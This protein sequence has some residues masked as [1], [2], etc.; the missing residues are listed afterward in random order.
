MGAT[1]YDDDAGSGVTFRAWAPF[2]SSVHVAG[3]FNSWSETQDP[4]YHE[5]NG[6]WSADIPAAKVGDEYKF[7]MNSGQ[8]KATWRVDTY[9]REVKNSNG[10]GVIAPSTPFQEPAGYSMQPWNELVIYELHVG[11]FTEDPI[12]GP[13]QNE[14]HRG[15]FRSIIPKL[16]YL[17]DLGINAI[18]LLPANEFAT[19]ISWGYNPAHLFAIETSY[20]G[21][22]GLRD[23]V[24][25]AHQN[26]IAVIFD[27][28]F[29][30][31][32][33]PDIDN[34]VWRF[35]GWYEDIYGGI[36]FYN[37]WRADT[38]WGACNR[39]DYGRGEVRQ[40]IRDS[41]MRW[42]QERHCDGLRW[43]A[44]N[45]IHNVKGREDYPDDPNNLSGWG[46]NLMKW[47][48]DEKNYYQPWKLSI[49]EDMQQNPWLTKP[50]SE[51]GAGFD[52]Q[53][54]AGF[55]HPVRSALTASDDNDRNMWAIK[56]AIENRYNANACSR[57][58]YTES[59][60]EVA[61]KNGKRRLPED[62]HP[63][64]ADSW[65]SKKRSTL[66]AAL[67]F[68]SPGIPMI[69]Q[70]QEMLEWI[71]FDDVN[72][73]DW[74]KLEQYKGIL[75]LYRDLIRL[76]RNCFDNT[77]GLRGQH[78]NVFHIN[79]DEKVIAFHRWEYGGTGD[80]VVVI[81]NFKNQTHDSYTIGFPRP[82]YWYV[83]FNSDWNGYSNNFDN[84]NSYNTTADWGTYDNMPCQGNIGIGRYSAIIL[85]Q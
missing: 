82:G 83:R 72:F 44:T 32:G 5:G 6:Y 39:P 33:P 12:N 69:L 30:H 8:P 51:N 79:N 71:P 23:L 48:N 18:Q 26:G 66:G 29:N 20:G 50:T 10:N 25:A 74:S 81:L 78:C 17:K 84:H 16:S 64:Q 28:V 4:L 52:S 77:R 41:A 27:V 49:A 21:P 34:S 58:I 73:V 47:I 45:F 80:D 60:D 42:L 22:D 13:K 38:P 67:A 61:S 57:V 56:A 11:T 70:G 68:T 75:Y 62:I 35:D 59:H 85:S 36:Y 7:V 14:K 55:H 40:I 65:E 15:T 54:D 24:Q 2:G 37:D 3:S 31:W 46:W 63:G 9:A 76:R 43:D 19:D 1:P 53:W